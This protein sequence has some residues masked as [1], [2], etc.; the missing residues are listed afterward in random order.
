[1]KI[2]DIVFI[3]FV[4][5]FIFRRGRGLWP[6]GIISFSLAGLLFLVGNLFTAQRF[7]W[8]GAG[9]LLLSILQKIPLKI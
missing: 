6:A 3:V 9:F 2:Q 5:A 4:M 1:M 8:Y 7:S